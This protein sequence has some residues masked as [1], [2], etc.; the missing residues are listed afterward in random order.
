MEQLHGT[1]RLGATGRSSRYGATSN[2]GDTT[3]SLGDTTRSLGDTFAESL[4][5]TSRDLGATGR[6]LG[7]T[8]RDLGGTNRHLRGTQREL[9]ATQRTKLSEFPTHKNLG[10]G[11]GNGNGEYVDKHG[12]NA[13]W[14]ST[15]QQTMFHD[16]KGGKKGKGR[17]MGNGLETFLREWDPS[18][19]QPVY[20]HPKFGRRCS[21]TPLGNGAGG[22]G[23][24]YKHEAPIP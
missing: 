8:G 21:G 20:K 9:G 5:A 16:T 7:A 24:F 12:Y 2:L 1:Q 6:D 14:E 4:Q 18:M 22:S 3:R 15:Y 13:V 23:S 17:A 11:C 19:V 10:T